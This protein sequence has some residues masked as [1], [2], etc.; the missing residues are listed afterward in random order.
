M[1]NRNIAIVQ[2]LLH[3]LDIASLRNF[4][5]VADLIRVIGLT[6]WT[7][8]G[9]SE[10][11][12]EARFI[13]PPGMA[14]IGQTP[15]QIAKALVYLSDI[16]INSY[17]EIGIYYGA[18]FFFVSEY[19]R[20]FNPEI[21]CFGVDPTNHVSPEIKELIKASNWMHLEF[22]TS[23]Q[24]VGRKFDLVLID[25]DHTTPWLVKDWENVGKYANICMFHDLQDSIWP[26][27]AAFWAGLKGAKKL[28]FLDCYP[29][30]KTQGIGLI[31]N[32][33]GK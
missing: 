28:E 33:V 4:E 31:H 1:K 16:K 22:Q 15:D 8:D 11:G 13:N 25:G 14:S 24:M 19:L 3:C 10:T 2:N 23:K 17:C 20:R 27:V 6:P 5:V 9:M 21:Q 7:Y 26:D 12:P 29:D 32:V 18:N 30:R